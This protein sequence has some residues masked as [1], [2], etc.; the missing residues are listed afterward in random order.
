MALVRKVKRRRLYLLHS[1]LQQFD[2]NLTAVVA[3]E[4]ERPSQTDG[5]R[6]GGSRTKFSVE[7]GKERRVCP[8]LQDSQP[9]G[10]R[11]AGLAASQVTGKMALGWLRRQ[12]RED[13]VGLEQV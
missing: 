2:K 1:S 9:A 11:M 7:V 6:T 4:E 12:Q 10:I 13:L 3:L 8:E 5:R